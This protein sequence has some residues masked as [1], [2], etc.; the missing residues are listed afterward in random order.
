M[1]THKNH[2]IIAREEFLENAHEKAQK[3]LDTA[4]TL[5]QRLQQAQPTLFQ[6]MRRIEEKTSEVD[7][8]IDAAEAEL[9]EAMTIRFRELRFTAS[10]LATTR[11]TKVQQQLVCVTGL[12]DL[13]SRSV[14]K[15]Q[16]Q[17][18]NCQDSSS[19]LQLL[20]NCVNMNLEEKALQPCF[21]DLWFVSLDNDIKEKFATL[22]SISIMEVPPQ[23]VLELKDGVSLTWRDV[24]TQVAPVSHYLLHVMQDDSK[25]FEIIQPQPAM[26]RTRDMYTVIL[27]QLDRNISWKFR[28]TAHNE[29]GASP[30]S[31]PVVI[32]NIVA[33]DPVLASEGLSLLDNQTT[34]V[35]PST[36]GHRSAVA[37]T[38]SAFTSGVHAYSVRI[39]S[40][41]H[42]IMV[43]VSYHKRFGTASYSEVGVWG[44]STQRQTYRNGVVGNDGTLPS[45]TDRANDWELTMIVD[46]DAGEIR[47]VTPSNKKYYFKLKLDGWDRHTPLVPHVNLYDANC[48]VT[49]SRISKKNCLRIAAE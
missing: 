17:L 24:A 23:P 45:P 37:T 13:V 46:L 20:Q 4:Q 29:R 1:K 25:D 33:F 28:V 7:R 48:T 6:M 3:L 34:L 15:A 47:Y 22:G 10:K 43:G 8:A 36:M 38:S 27:P 18:A 14:S 19:L 39:T 30:P 5:A 26:V 42:W 11:A 44:A 32:Q 49:L 16:E 2:D 21:D 40:N 41:N 35:A 31:L 12:L 9:Q